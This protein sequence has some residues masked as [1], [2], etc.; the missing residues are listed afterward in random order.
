MLSSCRLLTEAQA[1]LD[2]SIKDFVAV[3]AKVDPASAIKYSSP[4]SAPEIV[5]NGRVSSIE[6][7]TK[8]TPKFQTL[9]TETNG[10]AS[11]KKEKKLRD[12]DM[13]RRPA[14]AFFLFQNAIRNSVKSA[15]P[16]EAKG[17]EIQKAVSEK[18]KA[19]D[20]ESRKPY[21]DQ[22]DKE[23]QEYDAKIAAYNK[24]KGII[25][26]PKSGTKKL[27]AQASSSN[28]PDQ[29]SDDDAAAA[30]LA[31]KS[32]AAA[33]NTA[34]TG[35]SSETPKATKKRAHKPESEAAKKVKSPKKTAK[36]L[37]EKK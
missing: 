30:S 6:T 36:P 18:W 29:A 22:H 9:D 13:P 7:S 17:V 4:T 24:I 15:M 8:P 25:P 1:A 21:N 12:P 26:R 10:E 19:L 32:A 3:A 14:S 27:E 23:V 20:D 2:R 37:E 5:D 28:V 34:P 16:D 35:A 11:S 33:S 31:P